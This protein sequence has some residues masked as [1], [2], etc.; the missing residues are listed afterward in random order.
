VAEIEEFSDALEQVPAQSEEPVIETANKSAE[1]PE[2][3][4]L[5]N[6]TRRHR[7]TLKMVVNKYMVRLAG[8]NMSLD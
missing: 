4:L 1:E 6:G 7:P 3:E 8:K 5:T 2:W